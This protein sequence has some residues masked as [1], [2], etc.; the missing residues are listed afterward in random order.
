MACGA[1][2]GPNPRFEPGILDAAADA[3][4][5]ESSIPLEPGADGPAPGMDAAV[6][7]D[8]DVTE[9]ADLDLDVDARVADL[10]AAVDMAPDLAAPVDMAPPV[11]MALPVDMAADVAPPVELVTGLI[12][13]WRFDENDGARTMRDSSGRGNDG[14]FEGLA[15]GTGFITGKFGRAFELV[16]PDRDFGIRVNAGADIRAL[17]RYTLA[18][19]IYRRRLA[20]NE[21]CGIISRQVDGEDREV[22]NLMVSKDL[23]KTYGPDRNNASGTVTTAS[24]PTTPPLN[25]WVHVA[26]T[27]DGAQIRMY[28]N[29]VYQDFADWTGGLPSSGSAPVYLA[30]KKVISYAH[31]FIGALD[32]VMLYNRALPPD[33]IMALALGTRPSLP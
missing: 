22:F 10:Q 33:A 13:Y 9:S 21:Y 26:S 30:T 1:C 20:P 25:E 24:V 16:T 31:P 12:G 23:V 27:Y 28:Y 2:T 19:W 7:L 8:P 14:V 18:A 15:T 6:D 29:G 5:A 32:E 4:P 11:D 3:P 17:Q